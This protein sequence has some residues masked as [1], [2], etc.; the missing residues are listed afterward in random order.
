[1]AECASSI[2]FLNCLARKAYWGDL[3]AL[4]PNSLPKVNAA[5]NVSG[6]CGDLF[7]L[8]QSSRL[9]KRRLNL[10]TSCQRYV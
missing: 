8:I 6:G 2:L 4:L 3:T 5:Y 9:P 10:A 7:I 1:M